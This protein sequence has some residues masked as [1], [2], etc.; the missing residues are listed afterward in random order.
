MNKLHKMVFISLLVLLMATYAGFAQGNRDFESWSSLTLEYKPDKK[1][2]FGLEGELRLKN[3]ASDVDQ[4]FTQFSIDYKLFPGFEL[5]GGLRY[6]RNNDLQGKIQGYE[7]HFR[8]HLDLSY[9]HRTGA[10]SFRHRL[11][12]QNRNE[13]GVSASAG[14][15]AN[16]HIRFKTTLTYKIKNWKLD[17]VFS[18]EI[19]RHVAEEGESAFD[20][21]R[22]TIGTAYRTRKLGKIGLFY[23]MEH[24]LNAILPITTNIL[25]VKYTYSF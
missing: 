6:I 1:W 13:L 21:Y 25:M 11:R 16:K 8:F 2:T 10:F 3:D 24:T 7:K 12:Y 22:L 4:Y 14:D 18:A 23:R 20:K 9:R 19:F 15:I 17:P 5:G